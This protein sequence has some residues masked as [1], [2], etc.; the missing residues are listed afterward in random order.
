MHLKS[1]EWVV[2]GPWPRLTNARFARLVDA[3]NDSGDVNCLQIINSAITDTGFERINEL[4]TLDWLLIEDCE[5]GDSTLKHLYPLKNL[6]RIDIDR[7][8]NLSS[9]AIEQLRA[10]LPSCKIYVDGRTD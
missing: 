10:A 7:C 2:A 9:E 8:A 5:L 6:W 1:G 3:I 4:T